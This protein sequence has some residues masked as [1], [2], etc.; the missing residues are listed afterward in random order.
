MIVGLNPC[1]GGLNYHDPSV[2]FLEGG[3]VVFA[4]E[5]ERFARAKVKGEAP[6]RA[7]A[8]GMEQLG[9]HAS[10]IEHF[11]V[12]YDPARRGSN[13]IV[14]T[15]ALALQVNKA[16]EI[17]NVPVRFVP[18]HRSHAR[19][20][21]VNSGYDR[22]LVVVNDGVGECESSTLWRAD[23]RELTLLE[24]QDCTA[25]V[26]YFYA[27]IT[28]LL[29]FQPWR[30]EGLVM[31]LAPFGSPI[32]ALWSA[33]DRLFLQYGRI[34]IKNFDRYL[35]SGLYLDT[36]GACDDLRRALG[37]L[38][39]ACDD[40]ESR[41]SL[42]LWA[43]TRLE[44]QVLGDV[45]Q[46][47]RKYSAEAICFSG[48]VHLNCKLN[49]AV[50]VALSVP[51]FFEPVA[52]D[53]GTAMGAAFETTSVPARPLSHLFLGY[54]L[55]DSA[56]AAELSVRVPSILATTLPA[57]RT[58]TELLIA[59]EIV[60]WARGAAEFGPRALCHR[61]L[62]ALADSQ[63]LRLLLNQVVKDRLLWRP[64]GPV[65]RRQMA[66]RLLEDDRLHRDGR[67]M[68]ESFHATAEGRLAL[69]SALHPVDGSLRAQLIDEENDPFLNAILTRL[70]TEHGKLGLINTSLN[71]RDEP[72][73]NSETDVISFFLRT[74]AVRVLV[75]DSTLYTKASVR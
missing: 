28:A 27:A 44:D 43:Q 23:H 55:D 58:I 42:A 60:I 56:I 19:S 38:M 32:E 7:F 75:T 50:S 57:T 8:Y 64:F 73:C 22:A 47:V 69:S 35:Q 46:A 10:E 17:E 33:L 31:A 70:E 52:G 14:H 49:G 26:G 40:E 39:P 1:I 62:L 29:G 11:A 53:A 48:G 2:V 34:T 18:H 68:I 12:G 59:G 13:E 63:Q 51:A 67:F 16:L 24:S 74:K 36:S 15:L 4:A 9:L 61:S 54:C 41:A 65:L 72:I 71:G 37:S 45:C 3:E 30:D 25:S 21:F 66:E 6:R 5:E 20:A